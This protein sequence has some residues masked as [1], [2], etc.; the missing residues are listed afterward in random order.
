M[1]R[2][3]AEN[4][5]IPDGRKRPMVSADTVSTNMTSNF[6][7]YRRSTS[8]NSFQPCHLIM[9]RSLYTYASDSADKI[10]DTETSLVWDRISLY[11]RQRASLKNITKRLNEIQDA[12]EF[13]AKV[14]EEEEENYH[15]FPSKVNVRDNFRP[16]LSFSESK[17]EQAA[18]TLVHRT[19]SRQYMSYK[20][21]SIHA[22]APLKELESVVQK[23]ASFLRRMVMSENNDDVA[24]MIINKLYLWER[25]SLDLKRVITVK[26]E[27][28]QK[29]EHATELPLPDTDMVDV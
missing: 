9:L 15:E 17:A 16:S 23:E 7:S 12:L 4:G 24:D 5:R 20:Q 10:I 1:L 11:L 21:N 26:D 6:S 8:I 13:E 22:F 28:S 2:A 27:C 18:R 14:E 25:L 29:Q 19:L 3:R